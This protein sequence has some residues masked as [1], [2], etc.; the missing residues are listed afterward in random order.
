RPGP[1]LIRAERHRASSPLETGEP[2]EPWTDEERTD[3]L[4]VY[5]AQ[6]QVCARLERGYSVAHGHADL[7][8][9]E[10]RVVVFG[11]ANG[12]RVVRRDTEIA[13]R[14][15]ESRSL[16]DAGRQHHE[17]SA[18]AHDLAFEAQAVDRARHELIVN[19]VR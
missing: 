9:V 15:I 6:H 4:T 8:H 11:V 1:A 14:L 10:Q 19:R 2:G 18:V 13:Q 17:R 12:H 16:G 7:A 3:G 5:S